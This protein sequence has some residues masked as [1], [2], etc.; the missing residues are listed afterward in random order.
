MNIIELNKNEIS[1]ISG[2][3]GTP[4]NEDHTLALGAHIGQFVG[5]YASTFA[6]GLFS[7]AH[8]AI[9]GADKKEYSGKH[10]RLAATGAVIAA[11]WQATSLAKAGVIW[12]TAM[13]CN[14]AWSIL[15]GI[16]SWVH[17]S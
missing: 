4:Q 6:I 16:A 7:A 9:T 10:P 17:G 11:A 2:G 15:G 5:A 13:G 3:E 14:A 1:I 8:L 12:A